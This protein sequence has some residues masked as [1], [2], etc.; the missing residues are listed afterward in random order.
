VR[1][2]PVMRFVLNVAWRHAALFTPAAWGDALMAAG[3][4]VVQIAV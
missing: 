3:F 1:I 4:G 2:V